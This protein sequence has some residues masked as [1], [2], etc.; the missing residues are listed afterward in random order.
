M[1]REWR[2]EERLRG[3]GERKA[4]IC[5]LNSDCSY[6]PDRKERGKKSD[7]EDAE[8]KI[9]ERDEDTEFEREVR[10]RAK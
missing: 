1:R 7:D 4:R 2:A 6:K 3:K 9:D 10:G 5:S 8:I